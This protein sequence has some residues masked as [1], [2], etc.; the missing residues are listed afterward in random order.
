MNVTSVHFAADKMDGWMARSRVMRALAVSHAWRIEA[1]G[2]L[3][4]AIGRAGHA[5]A[6][7]CEG[8]E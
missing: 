3:A 4:G 5:Q 7:S 2:R 1:D 6:R 8:I